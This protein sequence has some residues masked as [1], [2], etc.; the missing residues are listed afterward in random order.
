MHPE[1]LVALLGA[2]AALT[3]WL[4]LVVVTW[5]APTAFVEWSGV[6]VAYEWRAQM[7]RGEYRFDVGL[8]SV[9]ALDF[10]HGRPL[11]PNQ[12]ETMRLRVDGLVAGDD[13][14]GRTFDVSMRVVQRGGGR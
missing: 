7:V 10:A 1:V 11:S 4:T 2:V 5:P 13:W 3:C 12:P 8:R 9:E 14:C 6:Y